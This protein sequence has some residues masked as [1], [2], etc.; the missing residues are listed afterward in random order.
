MATHAGAS[1][2]VGAGWLA[3][4]PTAR[5]QAVQAGG[6]GNGGGGAEQGAAADATVAHE[7]L[8]RSMEEILTHLKTEF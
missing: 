1:V 8:G 6:R 4:K 7:R 5:D 3:S 2:R